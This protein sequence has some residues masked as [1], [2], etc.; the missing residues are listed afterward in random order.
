MNCVITESANTAIERIK[1]FSDVIEADS[2]INLQGDEP[3]INLKDLKTILDY[4]IKFPE[5]VVFG[6]STCNQ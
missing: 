5:R 1:L 3:I 4:N 6:K 2:Y